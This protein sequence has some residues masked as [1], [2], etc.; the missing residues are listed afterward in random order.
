[1]RHIPKQDREQCL[2]FH[3]S[4]LTELVYERKTRAGFS[5]GCFFDEMVEPDRR[6]EVWALDVLAEEGFVFQQPLSLRWADDAGRWLKLPPKEFVM[7]FYHPE[8]GLRVEIDCAGED[9]P[10]PDTRWDHRIWRAVGIETHRVPESA[11]RTQRQFGT[12]AYW[13]AAVM[14]RLDACHAHRSV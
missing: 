4:S 1:M 7:D 12:A 6:C 11:V 14:R 2:S 10:A 8:L 9:Q 5:Q 13:Y 3:T